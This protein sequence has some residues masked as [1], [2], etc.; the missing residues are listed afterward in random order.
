[1]VIYPMPT[2][3]TDSSLDCK[4]FGKEF[5]AGWGPMDSSVVDENDQS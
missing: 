5:V 2:S 4:V 3:S 1:M